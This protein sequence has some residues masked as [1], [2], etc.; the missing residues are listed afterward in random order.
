MSQKNVKEIFLKEYKTPSFLIDTVK[1][2]LKLYEDQV[3]VNSQI[4]FYR[5]RTSEVDNKAPL[6]LN[7]ENLELIKVQIDGKKIEEDEYIVNEEYLTISCVPDAFTLEIN[8]IIKPQENKS[9]EGLY[10]SQNVFCTQCEAEGFRKITYYLDRP[11]VMAK[12]DTTLEADINQYP[13]LLSNGNLV[14]SGSLDNDRHWVRWEDPFKKPC[15]LFAI[16][17]GELEFIE[18]HFITHSGR[19]ITL[20]VFADKKNI[21]QCN[22]A[23]SSLK[24]AMKWDEEVFGRECDLDVYMIVAIDDFNSGAMENKGLNIFNSQCVLAKAQTATD[25]DYK[26]IESVIAHEY[27]HNWTGNRVTCRDW[28]QLSLKEGLTIFRDQEF[29]SDIASRAVK[30]IDDVTLLRNVQF[31]EDASP[32]SHPVR[33]SSYMEIRNFYTS[34]VYH[35]GAE[36]VRIIYSIIGRLSTLCSLNHFIITSSHPTLVDAESRA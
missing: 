5:N 14:A 30:R 31:P 9:L 13:V 1:L 18:D 3:K 11:D 29:S 2:H 16:I 10:K 20:K 4:N 33:P 15:Y 36:I 8:N 32:M 26:Y 27:F 17:A 35:K 23:I 12:F 25:Q 22:H 6:I 34:T 28:F 19:I 24:K 21:D 7:G